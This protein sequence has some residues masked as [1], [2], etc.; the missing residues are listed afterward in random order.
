MS[1]GLI[2]SLI[3]PSEKKNIKIQP[4]HPFILYTPAFMS[5][6]F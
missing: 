3:Q 5:N 4:N 2:F 6:S 1:V